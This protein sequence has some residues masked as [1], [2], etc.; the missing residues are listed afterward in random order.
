MRVGVD[1]M[2]FCDLMGSGLVVGNLIISTPKSAVSMPLG[3]QI[4]VLMES[5]VGP[6]LADN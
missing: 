4:A 2:G 5:L 6:S 3:I 1:L